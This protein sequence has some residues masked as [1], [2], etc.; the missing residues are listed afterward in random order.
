VRTAQEFEKS[1][2]KSGQDADLQNAIQ[3][4]EK[5]R[6]TDP[7]N[8]KVASRRLAALYDKAGEF[9]KSAAEYEALLKAHPKDADL[10]NDLGYSHYCRGDW[11]AAEA[12]LTKAVQIDPNHKKAWVN[13]GMAR[14]QQGKWDDGFQAFCQAVRPADAHCNVAFLLASQ[15]K[16]DDAKAQYRQA[17]ALDPGLRLARNALAR[18]E[19][20]PA[21]GAATTRKAKADPAEAAAQ[22]PM[23]AELEAR[24]KKETATGPA[25]VPEGDAKPADPQ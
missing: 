18:L 20:P 12:N 16:T 15:G 4:F 25:V 14:T 7:A 2:E 23:I 22:V 9:A 1:F 24:M 11:A 13:L 6:A 5:A 21:P 3:L 19:N 17:L 10:L 8:A